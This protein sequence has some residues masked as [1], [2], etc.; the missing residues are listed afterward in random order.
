MTIDIYIIILLFFIGSF[1]GMFY[2]ILGLKQPLKNP[3]YFNICDSCNNKYK[4]RELIPVFSYFLNKGECNY[5]HSKQSILIPIFELFTGFLYSMSYIKYGFSYEML[6][7]IIISSLM[8]IIFVSDFSYYI[9]TDSPLVISSIIIL[10]L[11]LIFFG[12][13]TF[14]LSLVSGGALFLFLL[15]IKIIG[16]KIFKTDSL[17][18][19]DVKLLSLFG[20]TL[21]IRLGIISL[22][23][24]ALLAFP[25]AIYSSITNDQKEI[26]FGPFL[27]SGLLLTFIYMD[28]IKLFFNILF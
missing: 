19:G 6:I 15:L 7:M 25:Y 28:Y 4:L 14:I 9:I 24:G 13:K 17:G 16:D 11:K 23:I 20:F 8:I 5:C 21:G 3:C 1:M 26:P 10:S 12:Y 22:I 2:I 18:G 27:I